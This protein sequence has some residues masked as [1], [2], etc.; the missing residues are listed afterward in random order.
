MILIGG[1]AYLWSHFQNAVKSV[2]DVPAEKPIEV[3]KAKPQAIFPEPVVSTP[4]VMTVPT[5]ATPVEVPPP[6]PPPPPKPSPLITALSAAQ[7]SMNY[8]DY[9][10]A[11]VTLVEIA[12][13][14]PEETEPRRRLESICAMSS[15]SVKA[16]SFTRTVN[17]PGI[18]REP[19][20]SSSEA[21][22]QETRPPLIWPARAISSGR[23]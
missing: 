22:S 9:S 19:F 16:A 4:P 3:A 17:S 7:E 14:L 1:G 20:R 23:E 2:S 6:A 5:P 11:M 8:E 13:K 15:H 10:S 12:R 18:W 21:L